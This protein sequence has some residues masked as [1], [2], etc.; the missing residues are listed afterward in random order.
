LINVDKPVPS[1]SCAICL[2]GEGEEGNDLV[3][4]DNCGKMIFSSFLNS[5]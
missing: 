4:C 5:K 1:D 3:F 2:G